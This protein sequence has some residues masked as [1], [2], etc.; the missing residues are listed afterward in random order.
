MSVY[1]D[2]DYAYGTGRCCWCGRAQSNYYT[3]HHRC[4][5]GDCKNCD[6]KD[7]VL[8]QGLCSECYREL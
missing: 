1:D 8:L 2:T 4:T 6:K 5:N 3:C 7:T